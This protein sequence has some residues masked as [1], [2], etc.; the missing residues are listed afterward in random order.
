M[1]R[2]LRILASTI[3]LPARTLPNLFLVLVFLTGALEAQQAPVVV[4]AASAWGVVHGET[5][6][7]NV[8]EQVFRLN[9]NALAQL[10]GSSELELKNVFLPSG[11]NV[12][13]R[14]R[15]FTVFNEAAIVVVGTER[16]DV[17]RALPD[18]VLF[19]GAVEGRSRSWAYLAIDP[20]GLSGTVRF[21]GREFSLDMLPADGD[22][23]LLAIREVVP[24]S[25]P[26]ACGITDAD[27]FLTESPSPR[28]QPKV[29]PEILL[30]TLLAKVAIDADYELFQ[31]FGSL[32]A[33]ENYI[34]ARFGEV[35][36]IYER[37]IAIKLELSYLRVWATE[38]DPYNAT[39][40]G[41]GLSQLK[42]YWSQNMDNVE[43][44][45]AVLLSRHTLEGYGDAVTAGLASLD[46]LCSTTRGYAFQRLSKNNNFIKGNTGVMAHEIGHVFGSRHTHS[47]WWNPPIDSCA[48]AEDGTCFTGTKQINGEIMSYCSKKTNEFRNRV[49]TWIRSR[50]EAARCITITSSIR[51]IVLTAPS[52]GESVCQGGALDISWT[53][54]GVG[55]VTI[56]LSDDN[57]QTY[58]TTLV[59]EV[60]AATRTWSWRIPQD[61]PPGT[62]YR[63]RISDS[64]VGTPI[65]EMSGSFE[66][67]VGTKI[68][69][70]PV[71]RVRC[72]NEGVEFDVAGTGSGTITY[73]WYF[74]NAPI[75]GATAS[76]FKIDAVA[77]ADSGNYF[78]VVK[79]DCGEQKS[80][81][82]TLR[83]LQKPVIVKQPESVVGC[84]GKRVA[85]HIEVEG[86]ELRFRW[87]K[88]SNLVQ[89]GPMA[90]LVIPAYDN[91]WA[92]PYFCEIVSPCGNVM[93]NVAYIKTGSPEISV[94][95]PVAGDSFARGDSITIT[96]TATCVDN[97]RLEFSSDGGNTWTPIIL[98]VRAS[99]GRYTWKLPDSET[100]NARIRVVS[101]AN[102]SILAESGDFSVTGPP[103]L[104]FSTT[105]LDFGDVEIGSSKQMN[106][107]LRNAGP[108][109]LRVFSTAVSGTDASMFDVLDG[110]PFTVDAGAARDIDVKFQPT[111]TGARSANLEIRHNADGSPS[112][113]ALQGNA[114][115]VGVEE[116]S[117]PSVFRL[118]QNYPNPFGAGAPSRA[119]A[120]RIAFELPARRHV[121]LDV[122]NVLGERVLSRSLGTLSSGRHEVRLRAEKFARGMY[123]YRITAG[124][125]VFSRVMHVLR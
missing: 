123:I 72:E 28:L 56:D 84:G 74:N 97:V 39:S 67:K 1:I 103:S 61:F 113:I 47:C 46:A 76:T 19:R 58:S 88:F 43:R 10:R 96:W 101:T 4:D 57:G 98:S 15:R 21:E 89:D 32:E 13:L 44:T 85:L 62:A 42:S 60:P 3:M 90:D 55:Y 118:Y 48:K 31:H 99:Y 106:V 23:R 12:S 91:N 8:K 119:E 6:V 24:G 5:T 115:V 105:T 2:M 77:K 51:S 107:T 54:T 102:S 108:G 80:D 92:G 93:S 16:G 70:Q 121:Q 63:I 37:D 65:A 50:A 75:P 71:D 110:A 81:I 30:D 59:T 120:T 33:A 86:D 73:Q 14:L 68:T 64:R 69:K 104:T 20:N 79:G 82:V 27:E 35:S 36:A 7:E 18:V 94:D 111:S 17:R 100:D 116:S 45:L 125:N 83:I 112:T 87:W 52:G 95:Q 34:I 38:N 40:L 26:T 11:E 49:A 9:K 22:S 117:V 41:A 53:S 66:I 25:Q 122:Y 124:S 109:R 78:C 29:A 114:V